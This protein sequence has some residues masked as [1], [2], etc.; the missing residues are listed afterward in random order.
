MESKFTIL[1]GH[2]VHYV[3]YPPSDGSKDRPVV[4]V[5]GFTEAVFVWENLA[6][7][8]AAEGYYVVCPDLAGHGETDTFAEVHGMELQAALVKH[9]MDREEIAAAAVIGHSMGGYVAAAF[10]C[11]YPL[12]VKGIGFFHSNA[13]ADSEEARDFR[14]RMVALLEAGRTS[15][16]GENTSELFA[17]GTAGQY[18]DQMAALVAQARA[19]EPRAI[20]AAQRGMAERPSRLKVFSLDVP[21]MFIIGKQDQKAYFGQV[22]AQSAMPEESHVL[23]LP[24]GHMGFYEKEKECRLFVIGYLRGIDF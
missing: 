11:L 4:L 2:R 8:L 16:I 3:C 6:Q 18:H 24:V 20:M 22:L 1:D 5:H 19:M 15:F 7:A 17:P 23:I 12:A 21:F 10:G 14:M 13:G 9:V